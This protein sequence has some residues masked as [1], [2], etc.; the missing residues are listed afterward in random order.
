MADA[1]EATNALIARLLAGDAEQDHYNDH[2]DGIGDGECSNDSDF[3]E[4]A[5]KR[6]RSSK[7]ANCAS[8]LVGHTLHALQNFHMSMTV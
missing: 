5:A 7:P 8:S 4:P 3:E 1:D 6:P 2:L